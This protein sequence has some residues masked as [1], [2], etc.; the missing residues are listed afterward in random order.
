VDEEYIANVFKMIENDNLYVIEGVDRTYED[1]IDKQYSFIINNL[2]I[3]SRNNLES[4]LYNVKDIYDVGNLYKI[5]MNITRE[6]KPENI[7]SYIAGRPIAEALIEEYVIND[8]TIFLSLTI[9]VMIIILYVSFR[10]FVGIF[11]PLLTSI[12]AAIWV[13]GAMLLLD[14]PFSSGTIAMPSIIIALGIS[15]II[16]YLSRYYEVTIHF[17]IRN[18]KE[19]ILESTDHVWVAVTLSEL[20][21]MTAF[22]SNTTSVVID[23]SMMSLLVSIGLFLN[24]IFTFTFVPAT[25]LFIPVPKSRKQSKIEKTAVDLTLKAGRFT[26]KRSRLVFLS[27]IAVTAVFA[28]GLFFLKTESSMTTFF[29]KNNPIRVADRFIN[30][31]LTGTGQMCIIFKMRDKVDLSSPAARNELSQRIGTFLKSYN[32][33]SARYPEIKKSK[34]INKYFTTDIAAMKSDLAKNRDEIEK[35][36]GIFSD[37]SNEFYEITSTEKN[38]AYASNNA[39]TDAGE[40]DIDS[41]SDKISPASKETNK[42]AVSPK[43]AGIMDI[44][45]RIDVKA[46]GSDKKE[47][48]EYINTIRKHLGTERGKEFLGSFNLLADFFQTDIKQPVTLRKIDALEDILKNMKEPEA[49]VGDATVKP[50]GNIMSI[51]DPLK[52]IYKVFYHEN[53]DAYDKIP[54]VRADGIQ[55]KSI[56]D[57]N[58]IGVCMNQLRGSSG[59]IFKYLL[60]DDLKLMQFVVFMRSD[61][62]DFLK[63]FNEKFYKISTKLFPD[64]D[65]YIEKVVISGMPAINMAMNTE[66]YYHHIQS[67]CLTIF[68][69]FLCCLFI[70]RSVTGALFSIIPLSVTVIINMGIMGYFDFPINYATVMNAS[71]AIGAGIDFTI[72]FLE[73]FKYE[74][75]IMGHD[76]RTSYYNTLSTKGEAIIISAFAI[77]GGFAVLMLSTFKM[78]SMSGLMVALAMLLSGAASIIVLPA[79][80][81]WLKPEFIERRE[82][83]KTTKPLILQYIKNPDIIKNATIYADENSNAYEGLDSKRKVKE[84]KS[85]KSIN[86]PRS[87]KNN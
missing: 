82:K 6:D 60:T 64:N 66:L 44:I 67:I 86:S 55:D 49:N 85:H 38:K 37:I 71:I 4:R 40:T 11:L 17:G 65:P 20:T 73:R 78:L 2:D 10:T 50:V 58:V 59:E 48:I 62:A 34:K 32:G 68:V 18:V 13:M 75:M 57:R 5:M 27:S 33:F 7:K 1:L 31:N 52:L 16:Y 14:I 43:D 24:L 22:L 9:I 76:F 19:A 45:A 81:N 3:F 47:Y 15:D 41:L 51:T 12:I 21:C 30:M 46:V 42:R 56:T 69:V 87:P 25:L 63:E 23:I 72:H 54:D 35:R 39:A 84:R 83:F 79:L 26:Y 8:M 28:I 70:F 61:K 80:L 53:N 29:M 77:A 36:I 74:H